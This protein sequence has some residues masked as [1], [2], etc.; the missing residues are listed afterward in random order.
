MIKE[1]VRYS[2]D[3]LA[4]LIKECVNSGKSIKLL[5]TGNSMFPTFRNRRDSV[6][7][8]RAQKIHKYDIVLHQRASGQYILHRVIKKKGNVLTIAGDN[9]IQKEYPVY[10]SQVLARAEGFERNGKYRS[11]RGAAFMLYS[12]LWTAVF[13]LRYTILGLLLK[14]RRFFLYGKG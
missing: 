13:P 6:V 12:V 5:V 4:P 14:L 11:C 8:T 9:E 7:L 2:I 3:D 10:S 1:D